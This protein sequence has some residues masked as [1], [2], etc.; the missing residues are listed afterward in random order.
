MSWIKRIFGG[1]KPDLSEIFRQ[2]AKI[3]D[4]RSKAEFQSGHVKGA[5]NVPLEQVAARAATWKKDEPLIMCCRSGMRSGSATQTLK[6]MGFTQVY[7]GG[8]WTSLT[9]LPE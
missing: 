8:P 5:I 6:K 2:G 4:V 3:I 1:G 7:N 9:H